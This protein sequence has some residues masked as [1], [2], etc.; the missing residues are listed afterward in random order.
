MTVIVA[1]GDVMHLAVFFKAALCTSEGV[2]TASHHFAVSARFICGSS[3]GNSVENIMLA[4]DMKSR[5]GEKLAIM[6]D[7]KLGKQTVLS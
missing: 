4:G 5:M 7:I 1:D 6:E 3:C 2:K